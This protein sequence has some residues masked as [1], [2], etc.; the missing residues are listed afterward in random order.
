MEHFKRGRQ[1]LQEVL[2]KPENMSFFKQDL[3]NF[4][5]ESK[6]LKLQLARPRA[7]RTWS[8]SWQR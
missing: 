7:A 4:V 8:G 2:K 1:D 3:E 5:T 6:L